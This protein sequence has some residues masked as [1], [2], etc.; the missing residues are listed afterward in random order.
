MN[1]QAEKYKLIE[2]I[3]SLEDN[4]I[5]DLLK[6]IQQKTSNSRSDFSGEDKQL[7]LKIPEQN[8][9]EIRDG[10]IYRHENLMAETRDLGSKTSGRFL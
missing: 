6:S 1:V 7:I 10:K 5:L 3:T 8:K 9:T 2:W 4:S